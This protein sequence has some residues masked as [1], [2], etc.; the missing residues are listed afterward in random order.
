MSNAF[1]DVQRIVCIAGNG[2]NGCV[3]FRREKYVPKGGPDGGGGG[4]GGDVILRVT[5]NVATLLD[6][7]YHPQ[8][9]GDRGQ[10]GKGQRKAGRAGADHIV[11]VPA[12]TVV[13]EEASG[14][15]CADLVEVDQ[16]FTAARGG[17]GG[18]GNA[19]LAT[20][21]NR[22]PKFA[23][24]G[25]PGEHRELLLELK[26]IADAALVGLPNAGKSTLL[27][28]LS[29]ANPKI[30]PYPF[31][32]LSPNLGVVED[33]DYRRFVVAD[34]PGLIE[35]AHEG[36]GLGHDFLR[37]IER[38]KVIVYLID[39]SGADPV[40]DY[41][42]LHRELRMHD[43]SLTERPAV[44]AANKLDLEPARA[45]LD[46][47]TAALRGEVGEIV[48]MSALEGQGI[49][50]M[51][52]ATTRALDRLAAEE[53]DRPRVF[54]VEA[55]YGYEAPWSVEPED[56]AWRVTGTKPERWAQMTDWENDEAVRYFNHRLKKLGLATTL[57]RL[58]VKE[59]ATVRIGDMEFTYHVG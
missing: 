29:A 15:I 28:Q 49:E 24:K 57:G 51:R 8:Q 22:L 39:L 23:E 26:L 34:I 41:R 36:V 43:A 40:A 17:M 2:G 4:K 11:P 30:A 52:A 14:Q 19:V 9:K 6:L 44:V 31:T 10:H 54:E 53:R 25:E 27:G 46:A 55:Y 16:E 48:P 50:D 18:R 56:G 1:V 47:F 58:G 37:H 21:E 5:E 59:D 7:K 45:Q 3:S 20:R 32:T 12:G 35:G 13:R 42:T 38:T 33:D